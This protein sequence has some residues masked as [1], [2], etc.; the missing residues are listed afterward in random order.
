LRSHDD[1]VDSF[2]HRLIAQKSDRDRTALAA[3]AIR[4]AVAHHPTDWHHKLGLTVKAGLRGLPRGD[5]HKIKSALIGAARSAM[6]MTR[7]L[8]EFLT[9]FVEH[10]HER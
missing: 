3:E 10:E 7:A 6:P 4:F 9:V 2:V 5:R 8:N 1:T